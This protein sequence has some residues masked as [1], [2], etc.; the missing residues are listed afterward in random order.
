MSQLFNKSFRFDV[1]ITKAN[2]TDN[3]FFVEGY[4]STSD[5]DRQGDIICKQALEKAAEALLNVNNTVF[6]GHEYDL[7]NAV[8]KIVE[9]KADDIGLKVKIYVSEWAEELRTKLNEGIINK[10]SIGGR[11]SKDR[12]ITRE[13]AIEQALV[14][15]DVGF[16]NINI[17][18][19][20]DLFEVSFVGVPANPNAQVV[21]L[22]KALKGIQ[23]V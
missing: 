10:F 20:I 22:A 1:E 18:E 19:G 4:A 3:K 11:V 12:Q 14:D 9:A 17:I 23:K 16:D 8:G 15:S 21:G 7:N 5:L 13:E 6:Y 2:K